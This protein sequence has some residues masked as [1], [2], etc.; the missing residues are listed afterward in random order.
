[1]TNRI[2]QRDEE[3]PIEAATRRLH[4]AG[5]SVGEVAR[6]RHWLVTGMN[7]ENLIQAVADSQVAAWQLATEQAAAVGMLRA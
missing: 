1:M 4:A 2:P 6:N 7:G 3:L 5:W